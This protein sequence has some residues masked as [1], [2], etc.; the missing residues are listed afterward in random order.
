MTRTEYREPLMPRTAITT[1]TLTAEHKQ[2]CAEQ[3]LECESADEMLCR[4]DLTE[5]QRRHLSAFCATWEQVQ[6]AEDAAV[7]ASKSEA[8]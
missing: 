2:W 5:E 1:S 4:D 6:G 7:R 3:N 8:R